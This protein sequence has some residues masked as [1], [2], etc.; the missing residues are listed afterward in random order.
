MYSFHLLFSFVLCIFKVVL[1]APALGSTENPFCTP[2]DTPPPSPIEPPKTD[3]KYPG[4]GVEFET[5]ALTFKTA[6]N[7]NCDEDKYLIRKGQTI[8]SEYGQDMIW[9]LS[10]DTTLDSWSDSTKQGILTAEYI[11]NGLK[12]KLGKGQAGPAAQAMTDS[13]NARSYCDVPGKEVTIKAPD[14]EDDGCNTWFVTSESKGKKDGDFSAQITVAMPLNAMD[15][16]FK[17]TKTNG[18]HKLLAL[19]TRKKEKMVWVNKKFFMDTPE[20]VDGSDAEVRGFF[21][22]LLTYAKHADTAN[23]DQ[24]AKMISSFM[25]RTN[26]VTMYQII[27]S[28]IPGVDIYELAKKLACYKN[29]MEKDD[30]GEW[31][32]MDDESQG[33]PDLLRWC[34][35]GVPTARMDQAVFTMKDNEKRP[36]TVP[37]KDW[38]QKIGSG[39]RDMLQEGD[40]QVDRQIGA[41]GGKMEWVLNTKR[42]A[43]IFEFRDLGSSKPSGFRAFVEAAEKAAVDLH[44]QY[45]DA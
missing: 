14:T 11:M 10:G 26:F 1:A 27:S 4:L 3:L 29:D 32:I 43:P 39:E 34:D 38:I 30:Q 8:N 37:V 15:E 6:L 36:F 44:T 7:S 2:F 20:G 9:W 35:N 5:S 18:Q 17:L 40:A 25:P 16:L 19:S 31:E 28:K 23:V 12:L 41:L 22:L 42:E 45:K 24:S 13:W 33:G 21:S